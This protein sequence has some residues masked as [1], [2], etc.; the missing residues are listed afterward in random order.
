MSRD[1]IEYIT[2]TH[3]RQGCSAKMA[4]PVNGDVRIATDD[5]AISNGNAETVAPGINAES[6]A[7]TG[8]L[9]D[10]TE[11][12]AIEAHDATPARSGTGSSGSKQAAEP[13]T[14]SKPSALKKLWGKL[15]LDVGTVMMMFK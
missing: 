6:N 15:G 14:P 9:D 8:R 13:E 2:S 11:D 3:N 4:Q 5:S 10:K 12:D 7:G 1:R